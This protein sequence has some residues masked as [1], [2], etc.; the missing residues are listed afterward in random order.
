MAKLLIASDKILKYKKTGLQAWTSLVSGVTHNVELDN[1]STYELSA[2]AL[3]YVMIIGDVSAIN[4]LSSK[5]SSIAKSFSENRKLVTFSMSTDG[6]I[7]D[8]N[9]AFSNNESLSTVSGIVLPSTANA[10]SM[11]ENTPSLSDIGGLSLGHVSDSSSALRN[12]GIELSPVVVDNLSSYA[13][14]SNIEPTNSID[15]SNLKDSRVSML[16]GSG[17]DE[18]YNIPSIA[19]KMVRGIHGN[20]FR[21]DTDDNYRFEMDLKP[22]ISESYF[23]NQLDLKSY[24]FNESI[25]DNYRFEMDLKPSTL[26][27]YF[28]NQLDLKSYN[29]NESIDDNYRFEMDIV[30]NYTIQE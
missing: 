25:D 1:D 17:L 11:L 18:K 22:N 23:V 21:T 7:E 2:S 10:Q 6:I 8:A 12:T 30:P 3:T 4:I 19:G 29:F 26:E 27:S 9:N 13:L 24:N 20:E 14:S 15:I 28:V 16:L 5:I